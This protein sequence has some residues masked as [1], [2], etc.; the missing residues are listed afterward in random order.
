MSGVATGAVLGVDVGY[1]P[2]SRTSAACCLEWSE[3]AVTYRVERFAYSDHERLRAIGSVTQSRPL[4]AAAFDGPINKSLSEIGVYRLSEAMLTSG[5]QTLIG[6]PGQSS[7]PNGRRLNVAAN[8]AVQTVLEICDL[9]GA[10]SPVAIHSKAI[11]EAFPTTFLGVLFDSRPSGAWPK[12][13]KSDIFFEMHAA[14]GILARFIEFYLPNRKISPDPTAIRNHDDRAG[15]VCALTALAVA[16]GR[17]TAVGCHD[18]GWIILPPRELIG[19]WA[20]DLLDEAATRRGRAC[21]V[22]VR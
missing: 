21:L 4:L 2:T 17:F 19:V 12:R 5:L 13:Q 3:T 8:E 14:S 7:S 1:S 20:W 9:A 16:A 6:K 10:Q 22:E 11:V 18:H 15:Y